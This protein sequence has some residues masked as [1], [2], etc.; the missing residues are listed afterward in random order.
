MFREKLT[1]DNI[2]DQMEE[3][4]NITDPGFFSPSNAESYIHY[5][6][7]IVDTI[8]DPA[9]KNILRV[10]L[11]DLFKKMTDTVELVQGLTLELNPLEILKTLADKSMTLS[12]AQAEE[13]T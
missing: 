2:R 8:E 5:I 12:P 7:S 1:R 10:V 6:E 9:Q 3:N 13:L 4:S 11:N